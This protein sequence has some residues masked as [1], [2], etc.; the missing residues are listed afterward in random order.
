MKAFVMEAGQYKLKDMPEPQAQ[1]GEVVV[2]IRDAGINRRDL[3]LLKRYGDNPEALIIGSDGAGVVESLGE[4]VTAFAIGDEV[5]INPGLRWEQN[6]DAPPEGFD[7]LGMPDHGT[8]AEK[9]AISA[10]QLEKKPAHLSWEE[11]GGLALPAMTG[12]RAL[13]TKGQVKKGDTLFIPGAG[14]GVATFLIQ[15]AKNA[16]ATVIVTSRSEDKLARAK[17]IGADIAIPTD[18]DWVKELEGHTIDLVIDSV[19][20]ATFNR[21]LDV[22]KKGGRIVI[23][24]ATTADNVDFNL[25]S[26]FYGQYQLFGST[27]GSREELRDMIQHIEQHDTHPVVDRVFSLDEAQEAFDYLAEGKQ[28]GKVVLRASE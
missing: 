28:F 14:S 10:Q 13:F 16:G 7:I 12:Y 6:S 23:F 27:M 11:A 19:G 24:G 9:I 17:E 20:G 2:K 3:G 25:R 1:A 26:F 18:S 22:L 8:F 21:S 5:I 15:F 4:G